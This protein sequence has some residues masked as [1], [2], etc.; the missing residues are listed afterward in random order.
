MKRLDIVRRSHQARVATAGAT[1]HRRRITAGWMCSVLAPSSRRS[2][3][4]SAD[5]ACSPHEGHTIRYEGPY[6][7][8]HMCRSGFRGHFLHRRD[9]HTYTGCGRPPS[10]AADC[11]D[12]LNTHRCTWSHLEFGIRRSHTRQS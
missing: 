11:R 2:R 4:T 9:A 3:C 12:S 6:Q 10:S 1:K 7:S 8:P 5:T